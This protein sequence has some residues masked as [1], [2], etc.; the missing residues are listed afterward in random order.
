MHYK[1]DTFSVLSSDGKLE[2]YSVLL[3][4]Q[5]LLK[6][7][8]R[9]EKRKLLKRTKPEDDGMRDEPVEKKVDKTMIEQQIKTRDYDITQHFGKRSALEIESGLKT[10]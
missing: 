1:F 6:K 7:L 2:F 4:E 10:R 8:T 5:A 9:S 3:D